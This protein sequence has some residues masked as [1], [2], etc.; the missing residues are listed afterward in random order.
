MAVAA[1]HL[2]LD[3][4]QQLYFDRPPAR[5]ATV[6]ALLL[7]LPT[8]RQWSRLTAAGAVGRRRLTAAEAAPAACS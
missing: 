2:L 6:E 5:V 3:R 7:S 1:R 8:L 4:V